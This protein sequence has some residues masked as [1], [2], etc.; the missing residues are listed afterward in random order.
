MSHPIPADAQ[1]LADRLRFLAGE[2]ESAARYGVPVPHMVSVSGH[3]FGGA[4]FSATEAEFSAWAEY[5]E[6]EVERYDHDGAHWSRA[7]ADLNGLPLS[8]GVK[9]QAAAVAS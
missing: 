6:A 4:S 7:E 5:T 9:H 1:R 3:E 2:I 8:F